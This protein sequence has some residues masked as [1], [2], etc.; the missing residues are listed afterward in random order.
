MKHF[1]NSNASGLEYIVMPEPSRRFDMISGCS[2]WIQQPTTSY[3]SLTISMNVVCEY[4]NSVNSVDQPI[5]KQC[6]APLGTSK[7][8]TRLTD[9]QNKKEGEITV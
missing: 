5:C 2:L 7:R 6:N 4:C 3:P 9:K 8:D 1:V